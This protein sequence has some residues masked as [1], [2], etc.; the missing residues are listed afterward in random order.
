APPPLPLNSTKA[1]FGAIEGAR[2]P[3][4]PPA[5]LMIFTR[6]PAATREVT[7]LVTAAPQPRRAKK[8]FWPRNTIIWVRTPPPSTTATTSAEFVWSTTPCPIQH[9]SPLWP[10]R[11]YTDC[12]EDFLQSAL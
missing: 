4:P 2:R 6:A 5:P 10:T 11:E 12:R 1:F 8:L 9:D 3:S 7:S